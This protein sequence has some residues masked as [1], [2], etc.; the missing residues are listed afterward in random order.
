MQ[1][2]AIA[3]IVIT[4]RQRKEIGQ[5][6]LE[7]LMRSIYSKGL[8]HAVVVS[9]EADGTIRLRAGERRLRA[10]E[11]LHTSSLAI[12]FN[13]EVVPLDHIPVVYTSELSEADLYELELDENL[14]RENLPW[15]DLNEAKAQLHRLRESQNPEHTQKQTGE[16][17]AAMRGTSVSH[18]RQAVSKALL[19]SAHKDNPRV[20]KAR[21]ENE[22]IKAILDQG[23]QAFKARLTQMQQAVSA[24]QLILGDCR[25]E[26][27]KLTPGT[28]NTIICDPPYGI[29]AHQSGKESKH[30]YDDSANYALEICE[31][32]LR[33][34][35]RLTAPRAILFMFCDI[36]HFVH[37]R[38]YA[39]QQAWTPYR[40]PIIWD[41]TRGGR[42]PWGR[43]GFQRSYEILLFAVKGQDELVSP[44]GRDILSFAQDAKTSRTH[45]ANKPEDLLDALIRLSTLP[46]EIILDPCCGSGPILSA[47][48]RNNVRVIGIESDETY[49]SQAMA[50]LAGGEEGGEGDDEADAEDGSQLIPGSSDEELLA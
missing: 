1:T 38:T 29:D 30:F 31:F 45:A 43:A 49:Y 17:I 16:E 46:G 34:G 4:D 40:T 23:E 7:D 35:F 10:I 39:S 15:Q 27:P 50:R 2:L 28:I 3:D 6:A 22:A 8:L 11:N 37:L 20:K 21:N 41:K 19:I 36:D 5:K 24:H 44:G 47:A 42:A 14:R 26:M 33:E 18:E 48:S 12:N 9:K 13:A 25:D 32:I